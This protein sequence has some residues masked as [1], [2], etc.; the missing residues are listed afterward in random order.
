VEDECG[1]VSLGCRS[2]WE[3]FKG[4]L[5]IGTRYRVSRD[6]AGTQDVLECV[7]VY[8][9]PGVSFLKQLV[10]DLRIRQPQTD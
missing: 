4:F 2:F 6:G 3:G 10:Y 8:E 9:R 7:V 1:L 5:E